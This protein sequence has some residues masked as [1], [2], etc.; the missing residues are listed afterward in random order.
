MTLGFSFWLLAALLLDSEQLGLGAAVVAAALLAVQVGMLGIGPA[1]LTLLPAHEDRHRVLIGAGLL[2]VGPASIVTACALLVVTR[3]LGRGVG[4]A[5][6]RPVVVVAFL[7]AV[8]FASSAY[9]LDHINVAIS[10]AD[11]VLM[12][13]LLQGLTQLA[14]LCVCLA[15]GYRSVIAVIGAVA[16]GA[17]ASVVL[18]MR[19]LSQGGLSPQWKEGVRLQGVLELL[20]LGLRNYPLIVADRA[21]GYLLPLIVAASLS[22]SSAAAWYVVWMLATAVFFVPQSAGYSLQTKLVTSGPDQLTSGP[23]QLLVKQALRFSLMLTFTAGTVL[24][25]VGPVVLQV[26][27]AQYVSHW[28][29]LP[30]LIP[31]LILACVTQIYY[32]VCR[33]SGLLAEATTIAGLGAL[34]AVVPASFLAQSYALP[35]VSALWLVAQLSASLAAAWRLRK[36]A[37]AG[38]QDALLFRRYKGT[39]AADGAS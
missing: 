23:D 39:N 32:G 28:I 29:L 2:I 30:I 15:G 37:R 21:P 10:R 7:V 35:G 5:W 19:Q 9:Q 34:I 38:K 1:T 14:V 27:G 18:G 11:L 16:A 8:F 4:Q 3:A 36:L 24:L 12:R 25:V 20:R 33:A 6:D 31:G 17:A 13:S 26:L 22:V